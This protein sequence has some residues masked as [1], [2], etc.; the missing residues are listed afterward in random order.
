MIKPLVFVLVLV[1]L[2]L[3]LLGILAWL[4]LL[5]DIET[6]EPFVEEEEEETR[7]PFVEEEEEETRD[8]IWDR[9]PLI[10]ANIHDPVCACVPQPFGTECE[11]TTFTNRCSAGAFPIIYETACA[12]PHSTKWGGK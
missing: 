2:I 12:A 9:R 10:C 11:P 3:C 1:F 6:G 8:D 7:E 5:H 4:A